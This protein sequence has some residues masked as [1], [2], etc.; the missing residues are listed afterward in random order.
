[1]D[2]IKRDVLI[3]LLLG[4]QQNYIVYWDLIQVGLVLGTMLYLT[5]FLYIR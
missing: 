4:M 5:I 3:S 2:I 1:M